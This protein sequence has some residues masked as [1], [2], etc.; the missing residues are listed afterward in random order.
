MRARRESVG[1]RRGHPGPE[2]RCVFA[3]MRQRHCRIEILCEEDGTSSLLDIS[4]G[5]C[6]FHR[7]VPSDAL[8]FYPSD[9][10]VVRTHESALRG[11]LSRG[12]LVSSVA[13]LLYL[14]NESFEQARAARKISK[15]LH[16]ELESLCHHQRPSR[17]CVRVPQGHLTSCPRLT[18]SAIPQQRML[19][20]SIHLFQGWLH[21]WR[22]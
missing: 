2:P 15:A 18:K 20:L 13:W 8:A 14:Y 3:L 4:K 21:V 1:I 22:P 19:P 17:E 11:R 12:T 10:I 16:Q 5:H 7:L 6:Y 9:V